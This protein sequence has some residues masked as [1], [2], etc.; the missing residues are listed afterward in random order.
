MDI[1]EFMNMVNII[2][3][4]LDIYLF[5]DFVFIDFERIFGMMFDKFL[6]RIIIE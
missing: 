6:N 3:W 2:D 4:G 5:R 1:E